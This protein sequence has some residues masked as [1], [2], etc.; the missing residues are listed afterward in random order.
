MTAKAKPSATKP[1]PAGAEPRKPTHRIYRVSG[2]GAAAFWTP[3][4]AAWPNKDG[5][6]F[7][8]S[9]DAVPLAGRIVMRHIDARDG[10]GGQQ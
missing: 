1:A 8:I 10:N 9:C 4:G 3:I 7:N 2:D 5:K 6:G